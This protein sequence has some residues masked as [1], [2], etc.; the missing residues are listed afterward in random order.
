MIDYDIFEFKGKVK[1]K[2]E[3]NGKFFVE[4]EQTNFYPDGKGG[5]LGDRSYI[6]KAKIL[7]VK[8]GD[9][10]IIHEVD[11]LDV[12]ENPICIID[13]ERRLE[14][15]R[16]HTA[17]HILSQAFLKLY[18]IETVSFHMGEYYS[19]IDL[20]SIEIDDK[21]IYEAE[22]LANKIVLENREVKKYYVSSQDLEKLNLRKKIDVEGSIRIVE[23][24]GFDISMCS[25]THVERTGEIGIIKV[26]KAEKT[27][28]ELTR[29]YFASGIRALKMFQEKTKIIEQI[30]QMLT[31]GESE[32]IS[33]INKTINVNKMLSNINR[34]LEEK[35]L[36]EVIKRLSS[37][38]IIKEVFENISRKGF[39]AMAHKLKN[40]GKSG[41]IVLMEKEKFVVATFNSVV[42][43]QVKGYDINGV[44]FYTFDLNKKEEVLRELLEK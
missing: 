31:T 28:K 36:D 17:Q 37:E 29:I 41:F 13:R 3:N 33:K 19:T 15:S 9:S 7:S 27:K 21:K 10:R 22:L 8:E 39:E 4:L 26:I 2:F 11:T 44:I 23:V 12:E 16:E 14:I 38:K 40:L 6:G 20:N 42:T 35:L 24:N 25:G 30:S 32:L 1:D 43:L 18:N 5:Q 34:S